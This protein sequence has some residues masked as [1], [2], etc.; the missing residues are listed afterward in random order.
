MANDMVQARQQ[1]TRVK[2]ITKIVGEYLAGIVFM[3]VDYKMLH[4]CAPHDITT[5]CAARLQ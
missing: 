4:S 1:P 5:F 2:Q 3:R